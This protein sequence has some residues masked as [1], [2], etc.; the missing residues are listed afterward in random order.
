MQ[1]RDSESR[2][3]GNRRRQPLGGGKVRSS[4]SP[5]WTASLKVSVSL[6]YSDKKRGKESCAQCPTLLPTGHVPSTG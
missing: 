4:L 6:D 2:G 1:A 5:C 3:A